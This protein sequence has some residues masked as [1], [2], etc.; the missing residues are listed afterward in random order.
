MDQIQFLAQLPLQVVVGV[1]LLPAVTAAREAQVVLVGAALLGLAL[2]VLAVL[3][4]LLAPL[5]AK[6]ITVGQESRHLSL[7]VVVVAV[8]ARLELTVPGLPVVMVALELLTLSLVL[9]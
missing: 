5:Q 7:V 6:V 9:L 8:P 4:T 1:A 2:P 3:A